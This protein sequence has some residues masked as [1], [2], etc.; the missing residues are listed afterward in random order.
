M[1]FNP[2]TTLKSA[3]LFI[4]ALFTVN[5][6]LA[7]TPLSAEDQV[8]TTVIPVKSV[9]YQS[10]TVSLTDKS[11]ILDWNTIYENNNSH[12][13]VERSTDML[14]FKTVALVLDGFNTNG[15]GKRYAYKED[16]GTVKKNQMVQYR[17]KQFDVYGNV[18]YSD[19][20]SVKQT[21]VSQ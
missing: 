18:S 20:V 5:S 8:F 10:L 14:N 6:L 11:V 9:E 12:F 1:K 2:S 17:L 4:I 16:N 21:I 15:T 3:T 13:E 19:V 7:T